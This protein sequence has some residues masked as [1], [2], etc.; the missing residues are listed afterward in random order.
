MATG[1]A[2]E[3]NG[4][5]PSVLWSRSIA[6]Q[7][8][9][10]SRITI[11]G[12]EVDGRFVPYAVSF[13]DKERD[14]KIALPLGENLI[15]RIEP[16]MFGDEERVEA[17]R[18]E[19]GLTVQCSEGSAPAGV[20]LETAPFHFPRA[21]RLRLVAEGGGS[22]K[23]LSLSIV[24]RGSDAARTEQAHVEANGASL[25]LPPTSAGDAPPLDV[26]L[27][28]PQGSGRFGLNSLRLEPDPPTKP[29][30]PSGTWLWEADAWLADPGRTEDWLVASG[31]G[32]VFLQ[33]KIDNGEIVG[34]AALAEFVSRLGKRGISVHAVE[35]DPAMV[36]AD[37]LSHALQ[38][39]AAIRR[40]QSASPP[41]GRLAGLQFDIEPYLLTDFARDP[42]AV[43]GQWATAIRSLSSTWGARVAVV[44]PF[45]MLGSEGGDAA[46]A[47]ARPAI[48][49][50]SVMAYRSETG[51]VTALSEPWLA[52]GAGN[53]VPV[54]VAI[55]NG[56]LGVEVHRTFVRAERGSV[57]LRME[58]QTATVSLLSGEVEASRDALAYAFRYE[59][60]VNPERIS[61][62]NDRDKLA[63]AR[64]ELARLLVAWPS[65]DGLVIH[66]LDETDS[67]FG[68]PRIATPEA[69]SNEPQ[70][71]DSDL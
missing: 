4:E 34:A 46:A 21:A 5:G 7:A 44:V 14:A 50:V 38:R 71:P 29:V 10:P 55:E 54:S 39:V 45:W 27:N 30:S 65:F 42:A 1:S 48:S 18:S 63:V 64:K 13:P 17:V 9:S 26:V 67:G 31:L 35:G 59:T 23:P 36:T 69:R 57:L 68:G 22:G 53:N 11:E 25:H 51:E 15:G 20:S 24:E 60:R 6:L 56:L 58:G 66:G 40:Y 37:G 33:L 52:W 41:E 16:R 2:A 12:A 62:M 47:A 49:G 8:P 28:C 70:A 19:D 3:M 43:W 61:F 32:R